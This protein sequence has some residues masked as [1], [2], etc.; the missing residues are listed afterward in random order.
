M[1]NRIQ[2]YRKDSGYE[3]TDRINIRILKSES[4]YEAFNSFSEYICAETLAD[5]EFVENQGLNNAIEF[6]IIDDVK[7][8]V[9]I[10]K[11]S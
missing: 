10:V 5:I 9:E 4:T 11:I 1:V 8:E 7:T 2:N 6:D 3:V